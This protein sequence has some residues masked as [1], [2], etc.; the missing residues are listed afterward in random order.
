MI[1]KIFIFYNYKIS[2][3]MTNLY[4]G[5]ITSRS[6]GCYFS[7]GYCYRSGF[8]KGIIVYQINDISEILCCNNA[9]C[10]ENFSYDFGYNPC[11][12]KTYI[13]PKTVSE[14]YIE[15]IPKEVLSTLTGRTSIDRTSMNMQS[16]DRQ[17]GYCE[18]KG[19]KYKIS[20]CFFEKTRNRIEVCDNI[21]CNEL[22]KKDSEIIKEYLK[23]ET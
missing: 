12:L 19:L 10:R 9:E 16:L 1:K 2:Y 20:L 22:F 3:K 17:C 5:L 18:R 8:D 14:T 15:E 6:G 13:S 11:K 23:I 21:C 7:C 4:K